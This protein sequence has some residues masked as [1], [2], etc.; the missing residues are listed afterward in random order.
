AAATGH[1]LAG[2][3][4]R[5]RRRCAALPAPLQPP[6]SACEDS[7]ATAHLGR[8]KNQRGRYEMK[9]G[10]FLGA[11]LCGCAITGWLAASGVS[12]SNGATGV[13][14]TETPVSSGPCYNPAQLASYTM[15][16]GL[17]GC[18]YVDTAVLDALQPSGTLKVSGTE[19][20]VGCLD[21]NN[22]G[23]CGA[24]DPAGTF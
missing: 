6:S 14:G 8:A 18:W 11:L 23:T 13:R 9:Y 1:A 3:G 24:D 16:G 15:T 21:R 2:A 20:F 17:V 4:A 12:A 22:D 7:A 5:R 19:H 10:R